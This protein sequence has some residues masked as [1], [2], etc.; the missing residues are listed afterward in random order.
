MKRWSLTGVSSHHWGIL[1]EETPSE[2]ELLALTRVL[3][4]FK[5]CSGET[6]F[7]TEPR[8]I[9]GD[10]FDF[11]IR[12]S[13]SHETA[14][15]LL[16]TSTGT[17]SYAPAERYRHCTQLIK[18]L[19]CRECPRLGEACLSDA[20][21]TTSS[22]WA[23]LGTF[24]EAEALLKNLGIPGYVESFRTLERAFL[25][26]DSRANRRDFT[27]IERRDRERSFRAKNS[28]M[29]QA[30][31]QEKCS[32]CLFGFKKKTGKWY[33]GCKSRVHYCKGPFA[34]EAAQQ[35]DILAEGDAAVAA[36]LDDGEFT[37]TQ[38]WAIARYAGL[39]SKMGRRRILLG[40]WGFSRGT[41][42][43]ETWYSRSFIRRVEEPTL[44]YGEV[45]ARFPDLPSTT[46]GIKAPP[47]NQRAKWYLLLKADSFSAR[48]GWGSTSRNIT[49]RRVT[50]KDVTFLQGTERWLNTYEHKVERLWS[51]YLLTGLTPSIKAP[52]RQPTGTLPA[53]LPGCSQPAPEQLW[54]PV[55]PEVLP[56]V[57]TTPLLQ[58]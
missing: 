48:S 38:F 32:Q 19:G 46:A 30:A 17:V 57:P 9:L 21:F 41:F 20:G 23:L 29:T 25:D 40:G 13:E 56:V 28:A 1:F 24:D 53:V 45:R 50:E 26:K 22:R 44:N 58:P 12:P 43:V 52:L 34:D 39:E 14:R 31:H 10:T 47:D 3:T 51:L 11:D 5:L 8:P 42:R 55:V 15:A 4:Q 6:V 2:S 54:L 27:G 35:A 37:V 7:R 33:P 49:A 36:Y 18:V 16:V